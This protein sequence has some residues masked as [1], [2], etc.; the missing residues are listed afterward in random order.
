MVSFVTTAS[1]VFGVLFS[2]SSSVVHISIVVYSS[3][4][5]EESPEL[6]V[7]ETKIE[8]DVVDPSSEDIVVESNRLVVLS[9]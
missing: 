9:L 2:S 3:V 7:V 8:S 6:S 5:S 1:N 4:A